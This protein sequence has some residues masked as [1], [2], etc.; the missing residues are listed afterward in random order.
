MEVIVLPPGTKI[1]SFSEVPNHVYYLVNGLVESKLFKKE[2][3]FETGTIGEWSIFNLPSEEQVTTITETTLYAFKPNEILNSEYSQKILR[4]MVSSVAKRLLL[5][6]SELAE[7]RE[8][9][10]YVGPDRMRYLNRTH[11]G[12]YKI[13]DAI[14]QDMMQ[15]KR[16]YAAGY[17]KEAFEGVVKLMGVVL[18]EDLRKEIMIWHTLLSIILDPEKAEIH[19]KRLNPKDYGDSLSYLYL[20][21][22]FKGGERQE[23]LEVFMKAGLH[24]PP[25][26]IVTL[27]G[28]V[29]SESFLVLRGYL[30]AVKLFED[31]EVLLTIVGPSEFVGES[32]LI[33]SRT[34][35]ITLYSISPTD[36]IALTPESI[37]KSVQS[38]PN[39][40]LKICE[41]QLK[42]ISQVKKLIEIR[43]QGNQIQRTVIAIKYFEPFL[44]KTKINVRDIAY[45]VDTTIERVMDEARRL[46]YKISFDGT[47]SK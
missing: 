18:T 47:I 3:Q 22:F 16:L 19:F 13:T 45:L 44:D 7:C 28:E 43:N 20:V 17:Y 10:E 25:D 37:E 27:E 29:A 23:I 1:Y 33:E 24:I 41:S 31:K 14:F 8:I 46:G 40:I 34:R 32:A 38:N 42:R 2:F 26:T 39:F 9:P 5:V 35:M 4:S 36:I 30:K 15:V 11:P 6:D 21:N 12:A